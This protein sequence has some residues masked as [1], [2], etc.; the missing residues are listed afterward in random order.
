MFDY[1]AHTADGDV[2]AFDLIDP[3]T[4]EIIKTV[5]KSDFDSEYEICASCDKVFPRESMTQCADTGCWYC[6]ECRDDLMARCTDCDEWF[7]VDEMHRLSSGR[8][9]CCD[10]ADDYG[11]YCNYCEEWHEFDELIYCEDTG[12][13]YCDEH[14]C[15]SDIYQCGDC[16]YWYERYDNV[17]WNERD[18]CY[19]C[20]DCEQNHS[21]HVGVDSY[22]AFKNYCTY[23]GA[24]FHKTENE[25]EFQNPYIGFELETDGADTST[26]EPLDFNEYEL[27]G[28]F[29]P[30]E[31][32]SLS[33][34]GGVEW[35]SEPATLPYHMSQMDSYF[36]FFK[37]LI[38]NGFTAHNN[39]NCGLHMHLDRKY[40]GDK[41]HQE[42]AA[43][44]LMFIFERHWDNLLKFSR[45]TSDQ[46]NDWC[47]NTKDDGKRGSYDRNGNYQS[48]YR[49]KRYKNIINNPSRYRA[50]NLQNKNTIEIR[51]WRG[52]LNP[53]TFEATLKLTHR[54]AEIAKK[55][56]VVKLYQMQFDELLGDDPVILSYWE[57]VKN[58]HI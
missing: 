26:A 15:N 42:C 37:V 6:D 54:L 16:G 22:H 52:S 13:Y 55:T 29:H 32:G 24:P 14:P 21:R 10:C 39:G 47:G 5:S 40:F 23:N 31:D 51:L 33:W 28:F 34:E 49:G 45:R 43:A 57:R 48:D 11:R 7:M 56:P 19:Y 58:R 30:E 53:E 2:V 50:I 1:Y 3:N 9:V 44:K 46:V 4:G 17:I 25:I 12:N 27:D 20:L 35:V 38:R 18:E 41:T 8:W 36:K